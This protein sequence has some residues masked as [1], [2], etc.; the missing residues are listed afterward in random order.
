MSR[1]VSAFGSFAALLGIAC[2]VCIPAIA[3]VFASFGLLA[4]AA[5]VLKPL[6]WVLL[7]VFWAGLVWS[8]QRHKNPWPLVLGCV[9]GILAYWMRY[10]WYFRE[11]VFREIAWYD[12][13]IMAPA[14]GLLAVS[15]W[16]RALE[17]KYIVCKVLT[18]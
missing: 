10:V 2:P 11:S 17:K 6:F 16:N 9:L 3:S 15:L 1:V 4:F 14:I 12:V 13:R 8:Y 7:I 18:S 5:A